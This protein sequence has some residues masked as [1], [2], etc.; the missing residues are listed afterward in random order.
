TIYIETNEVIQNIGFN[1]TFNQNVKTLKF[2]KINEYNTNFKDS[3]TANVIYITNESINNNN[4]SVSN[5][6]FKLLVGEKYGLK[7]TNNITTQM[8]DVVFNDKQNCTALF[9]DKTDISCKYCKNS[10]LLDNQC[11]NYDNNCMLSTTQ[12]NVTT[13]VCESCPDSYYFYKNKCFECS[14]GCLKCVKEGCVL[15]DTGYLLVQQNGVDICESP[16]NTILAKHNLIMKCEEGYYS[17]YAE[18]V[19][20][21]SN[22]LAC[23][24]E[25]ICTICKNKYILQNKKCELQSNAFLTDN[26]NIVLCSQGFYYNVENLRCEQCKNKYGESCEKCTPTNC[27]KCEDSV[28]TKN[29]LCE[30]ETTTGCT[31]NDNVYCTACNSTNKFIDKNGVCVYSINCDISNKNGKCVTCENTYVISED[32]T[33]KS[34]EFKDIHCSIFNSEQDRCILC[35]SNYYLS[36]LTC[37]KCTSNCVYCASQDV[38]LICSSLYSLQNG[39]CFI[40]SNNETHCKIVI[41]GSS[42]CALCENSFFRNDKGECEKCIDN[43]LF[44]NQKSTCITCNEN[45]FL[46]T[47]STQCIQFDELENCEVKSKFGCQKCVDGFYVSNQFCN[48]CDTLTTFCEKCDIMGICTSCSSKYILL[49]NKCLSMEEVKHCVEVKS[50][51]CVKCDFWYETGVTQTSCD[52]HAVWW[53]IL[54]IV[55]LL[56]ILFVIITLLI[57]YTVYYILEK[58]K[59]HDLQKKTCLFSMNSSNINF[60]KLQNSFIS[61]NKTEIVFESEND[62]LIDVDCESRELICVGNTSH[63]TIKVQFTFK[64]SNVKYQIRSEPQVIAIP[65]GKAVEFEVFIMPL[66]STNIDDEITLFAVDMKKGENFQFPLKISA[67]TKMTTRLDFDELI[68]EKEIGHGSFGIVYKGDFIVHFYGAV[69]IPNKVCMVTEF[70][71]FGSLQDLIKK[72]PKTSNKNHYTKT[73]VIN[74]EKKSIK[75]CEDE[76]QN[77]IERLEED[78]RKG[79]T[80]DNEKNLVLNDENKQIENKNHYQ[81][82]SVINQ[83]KKMKEHETIDLNDNTKNENINENCVTEKLRIKFLLDAAKG[84]FYLHEN[85]ILHRDIKPDNIL[86]FSMDVNERVNAKL[87]DFGSSRNINLLMTNMTFTKGVGTPKYMAPEILNKEKYK[88]SADIFSFGVTMYECLAWCESYSKEDFRYPWDIV[89]YVMSGKRQGKPSCVSE[90]VFDVVSGAWEQLPENRSSADKIVKQLDVEYNKAKNN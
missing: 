88:K 38:C 22:C 73:S 30:N 47:N 79:A 84:V 33:C 36:N 60:V 6:K 16:N 51:K 3:N 86:V 34:N 5:K 24:D 44:C 35:E 23:V 37:E 54:I 10:Y 19:K 48:K 62:T 9:I 74:N 45:T 7:G 2:T 63:H 89:D 81:K 29:N 66:C 50:S 59:V 25:S 77:E 27:E 82:T 32:S 67:Q 31:S 57:L 40:T 53:I 1:G 20:C 15:C 83:E 28:Y 76:I 61:V 21:D 64:T 71:A 8:N 42:K 58:R 69:L 90:E 13:K 41:E 52:K 78:E 65:K 46:L 12:T 70:A 55:I 4:I 39:S 43:C 26:T 56:L 72:L 68:E 14:N 85:G 49:N 87:T 17:R 18:C 80:F 11:K 75:Y